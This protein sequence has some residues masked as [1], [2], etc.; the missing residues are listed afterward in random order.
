MRSFFLNLKSVVHCI[1]PLSNPKTCRVLGGGE[2]SGE[3]CLSKIS[4]LYTTLE[5][6]GWWFILNLIGFMM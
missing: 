6:L 4:R 5:K 2:E 3:G 1:I